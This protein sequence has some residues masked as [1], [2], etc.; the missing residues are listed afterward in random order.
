[1][2]LDKKYV[3]IIINCILLIIMVVSIIYFTFKCSFSQIFSDVHFDTLNYQSEFGTNLNKWKNIEIDNDI[4]I[5]RFYNAQF[6]KII[7][8]ERMEPTCVLSGIKNEKRYFV[9]IMKNGYIE[10]SDGNY[11]KQIDD[12]SLYDELIKEFTNKDK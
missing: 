4:L 1:M 12:F 8:I 7:T 2:K 3:K 10:T 6:V 11:Y 9:E 5:E